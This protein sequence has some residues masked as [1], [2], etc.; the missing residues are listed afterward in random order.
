M[1]RAVI[2]LG[3]AASVLLSSADPAFSHTDSDV[4]AVPA[5]AEAT[6]SFRP[7]HGCGEAPTIEVS[8]RAPVEGASAG[9]VEGWTQSA[10]PDG[11]GNTILAWTGGLLPTDQA[12]A[13]PITFTAP[14]TPG[15][16]L[17]F[18]AVQ[19]CEGDEELA[20]IGGDPAADYPAPRLLI[21]PAGSAPA[22]TLD[23]VPADAPGR[24]QLTQIVDVDNPEEETTT[25]S[26]SSTEPEAT[27]TTTAAPST[28][29]PGDPAGDEAALAGADDATTSADDGGSSFPVAP[30]LIAVAAVAVVVYMV[31]RR[32]SGVT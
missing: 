30:V 9:P 24:G 27:S 1:K 15:E 6:V 2:L 10:T 17:T 31:V 11:E 28:T 23:D 14:D 4:V 18:P 21:L 7:T 32:R 13:F 16:L 5:G 20:W 22:A 29:E 25:T 19:M 12:G 8:V 26:P 3:L